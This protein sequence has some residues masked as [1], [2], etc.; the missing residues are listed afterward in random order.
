MFVP[1]YEIT[2]NEDHFKSTGL[3]TKKYCR[4]IGYFDELNTLREYYLTIIGNSS[5]VN[6]FLT[7]NR[8]NIFDLTNTK[9]FYSGLITEEANRLK[10]NSTTQFRKNTTKDHIIQRKKFIKIIMNLLVSDINVT[11]EIF[12]DM[13]INGGGYSIMTKD[14]HSIIT[15]LSKKNKS[16]YNYELYK[17]QGIKFVGNQ[18]FIDDRLLKYHLLIN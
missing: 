13:L 3:S 18:E 11:R 15:E 17:L 9:Q 1:E 12:I 16:L 14:E 5:K 8:H 2:I 4:I 6:D 7:N 10:I